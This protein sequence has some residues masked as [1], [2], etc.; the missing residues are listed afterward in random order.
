MSEE[1]TNPELTQESSN[2]T[3][4]QSTVDSTEV[5]QEDEL[6]TLKKRATTL[7]IQFHPAIGLDKLREKVAIKLRGTTEEEVLEKM[8]TQIGSVATDSHKEYSLEELLKGY[9]ESQNNLTEAQSKNAAIKEANKLVRIRLTCMNPTKRDFPGEI[10]TVS[11]SVVGTLKKFIP[12]NSS[13]GYHVPAMMLQALKERQCQIWVN[14]K[15][16]RGTQTKKA[17]LVP[18]FAIEILPNLTEAEL[19]DLAQRQAIVAGTTE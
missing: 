11:N 13:E 2:E 7:G 14:G 1:N 8:N 6:T 9:I 19:K 3:V 5:V 17:V 4:E 12:F 18:E 16:V 10:I 15:D